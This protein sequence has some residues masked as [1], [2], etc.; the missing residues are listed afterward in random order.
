MTG[1]AKKEARRQLAEAEDQRLSRIAGCRLEALEREYHGFAP[2]V[3][4]R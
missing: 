1:A 3:A 2:A 4:L